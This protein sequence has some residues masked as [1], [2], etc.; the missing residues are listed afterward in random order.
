MIYFDNN[1]TTLID[2]RVLEAMLPFLKTMYG[3]PSSVHRLG[4]IANSAIE[5]AREQVA[6]FIDAEP[7]QVIFTSGGTEANNLALNSAF[8]RVAI[9]AIEHPSVFEPA[10]RYNPE[11]IP[12]NRDGLIDQNTLAE[13]IAKRPDF[14]SIMLANNETGV[15]QP[16]AEIAK[17][18]NAHGVIVHTDAVQAVGKIP[19]SFA[20]LGVQMLSLSGHKIYAPK[21]CGALIVDKSVSISPQ[22]LGGGQEQNLR[23]GTENVAAIVG[24]GKACELAKNELEFRQ[25]R[26]LSLRTM[27]ENKLGQS[28]K[29]TI[30]AKD[31]PRLPNTVLFG[32]DCVDGETVLLKLDQ[33]RI[34]VSSGSACASGETTPS[35]VL[36][37]MGISEQQAKTALRVSLSHQNTAGEVLE[38]IDLI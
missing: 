12:V 30:F 2:E 9:S 32:I 24:F 27:L 6:Y 28:L 4:R 23:S 18:L 16:I 17:K 3:N 15:I 8:G 25:T 22:L 33:K 21:G 13:V 38:F 31:A 36:L 29:V 35:H 19:V 37:A 14:V 34:C 10:K 1:A 7:S 26:M 5:T 20:D 11:I